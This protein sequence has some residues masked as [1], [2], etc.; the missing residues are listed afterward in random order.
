MDNYGT[1]LPHV[2]SQIWVLPDAPRIF[3]RAFNSI[4]TPDRVNSVN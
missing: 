2:R 3:L 1:G 4:P